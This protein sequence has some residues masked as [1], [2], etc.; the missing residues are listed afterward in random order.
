MTNKIVL[1]S[2]DQLM[3]DYVP[4]YKP[5]YPLFLQSGGKNYSMDVGKLNFKR[6]EAVG[7]IRSKHYTPKDTH[8]HQIGAKE[9]QKTFK[10]YPLA[11]QFIQST[12]QDQAQ[13]EAVV[14]QVLD[15]HQRQYDE[16][17]LLGDGTAS[18]NVFNNALFWS[19]DANWVEE[20]SATVDGDGVDPLIDLHK[21]VMTTV[22]DADLVA[23]RKVIIFYG[24]TI[25][26]YYN[27]VYAATS[28][29]FKKVLRETLDANYSLARIP[30]DITPA[31]S[32]GWIIA[33]MD[34][35][36]LHHTLLP[37]LLDQGVNA[38]KMH[39]W[40][41]FAMGSCMLEVLAGGAVIKQPATVDL[42]E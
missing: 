34:Q 9:S 32:N 33:N 12:F 27:G 37:Q 25:I 39:S 24:T 23:G 26:P 21:K 16:L 41:N 38:E 14:K 18:N 36:S 2:V 7:D 11:S 28:I 10:K 8:I 30:A 13:N 19:A 5:L 22:E 15:E 1:R 4:L 31:N 17:F 42:G 3:N 35:V 20:S 29:P 6:L 40:H